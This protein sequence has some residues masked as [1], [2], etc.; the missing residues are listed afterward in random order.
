MLSYD[1]RHL[2]CREACDNV[3]R[4]FQMLFDERARS[5]RESRECIANEMRS[6]PAPAASPSRRFSRPLYLPTD[7]ADGPVQRVGMAVELV[8]LYE[9]TDP[10]SASSVPVA[11]TLARLWNPPTRLSNTAHPSNRPGRREAYP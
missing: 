6:Q 8:L 11:L 2:G 1:Y 5:R 4:D 9:R 3:T 7:L 10:V